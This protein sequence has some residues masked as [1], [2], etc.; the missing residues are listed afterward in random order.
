[1]VSSAPGDPA[2]TCSSCPSSLTCSSVLGLQSHGSPAEIGPLAS[3]CRGGPS[4]SD[5]P[6][7]PRGRPWPAA[8]R[9][10]SPR[11]S[12]GASRRVSAQALVP[13]RLQLGRTPGSLTLLGMRPFCAFSIRFSR[14]QGQPS[15]GIVPSSPPGVFG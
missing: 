2:V 7:P 13:A 6:A 4:P 14:F 12:R 8:R 9:P 10:L 15:Q 1:M 3:P 5:L 11:R